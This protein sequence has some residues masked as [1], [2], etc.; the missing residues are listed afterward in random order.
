MNFKTNVRGFGNIV[1]SSSACG[2]S[3]QCIGFFSVSTE[4]ETNNSGLKDSVKKLKTGSCLTTQRK[5]LL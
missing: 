4:E 5:L 3:Y 2:F 1:K